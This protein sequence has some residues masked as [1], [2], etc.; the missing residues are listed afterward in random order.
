MV[1]RRKISTTEVRGNKRFFYTQSS[2]GFWFRPLFGKVIAAPPGCSTFRAKIFIWAN[3]VIIHSLKNKFKVPGGIR[4]QFFP[5]QMRSGK[6]I[7][8]VVLPWQEGH[9]RIKFSYTLLVSKVKKNLCPLLRKC[10]WFMVP[11]EI[12]HLA[13]LTFIKGWVKRRWIMRLWRYSWSD[14]L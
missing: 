1:H 6:G 13:W 10:M 8:N 12:L 14:N 3:L 11:Q 7:W 9:V 4:W 5:V 2:I